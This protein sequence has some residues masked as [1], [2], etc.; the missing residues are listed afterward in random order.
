ML[1]PLVVINVVGLTHE[2]LGDKTPNLMRLA[3]LGF[4]RP[5]G[6]V[7]PAVTCSAQ[8]T[9]LTGLMP[10][11][12]G[13]VANGWYF[14]ELAE[15]MFWKQSNKLVHG[16]TV[17]EAAK[18]R[19]P[20]YTTAKLFWWYNMYAPVD[21]SVTPRPSY[22]ADGR[23]VFDS[24][25][26]PE[27]LKDELQSEL[28]VFP[29]LKFWGPG[30]DISSSSWIVDASIKVFQEKKPSLT[31]V[32][33]PHLDYN[34]Q[35]L[36]ASDPAIDQDIRDI[37]REAGRLIEVAQNKGADVV[38]LSEYTITNVSK[39][40]HIN[41]ILREHGW[42]QVRKEALGWETLDCGASNAF[43]VADHQI[44][45]VYIQN[46]AQITE[47]KSALEKV[48]GIEMVLDQRQQAEFGIDHERSGELVVV[49][50]PGSWFT[51]YFWLD[52]RVAPDYARTVDIHRKPGYDP[53]EL[54]VDPQIRFPKLRIA[55]RLAKKM[56]GFRYYMDLTSLDARLVKGSHGRLPSPGREEAESPVFICSSQSIERDEIPMTA[57]KNMLLE[58]QFGN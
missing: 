53:V 56:L 16:E 11:E 12:H 52:D 32:Y 15:V 27:S 5:M 41:R 44:A 30:A 58:L 54:F 25:S 46:S 28:G 34:L 2:M 57:V 21:W 7:L 4:S 42:L 20:A 35:R 36:G 13:I 51:Y 43:A 24:Y 8:S 47:I 45:H 38:V 14:H 17:Y 48:D 23:K 9:L 49:A 10:R 19:D 26:Q 40:V 29:L 37:D 22:P 1:K 18:Q 55:N 50:A 3:N 33:L 39:P 6:T 31:L